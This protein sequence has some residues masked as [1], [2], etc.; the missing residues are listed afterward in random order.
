LNQADKWLR[1]CPLQSAEIILCI[2]SSSRYS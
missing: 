1:P 2:I